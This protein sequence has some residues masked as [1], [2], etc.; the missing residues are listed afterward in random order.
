[1]ENMNSNNSTALDNRD[2][3]EGM[4]NTNEQPI[5]C[6]K[7]IKCG[8]TRPASLSTGLSDLNSDRLTPLN[9]S[10]DISSPH[11]SP[12][13]KDKNKSVKHGKSQDTLVGDRATPRKLLAIKH[14]KKIQVDF[15]KKIKSSS[16]AV[17]TDFAPITDNI[18]NDEPLDRCGLSNTFYKICIK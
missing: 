1:M 11:A 9:Q 7:C 2:T 10:R 18:R 6:R 14:H 8:K 17:Q 15:G 4:Q 16:T 5:R 12:T 13:V 3:F